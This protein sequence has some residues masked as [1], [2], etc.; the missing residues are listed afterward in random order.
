MPLSSRIDAEHRR[1]ASRLREGQR[2]R[3]AI[4]L[5]A[6][7]IHFRALG[8]DLRIV[9]IDDLAVAAWL[10]AETEGL[11]PLFDRRRPAEQ[12]RPGNALVNDDL[13]CA[14]HALVLAF[15]QKQR[16]VASL[17]HREHRL[18]CVSGLVDEP[19]ELLTIGLHIGD[20]TP[21]DAGVG[22]RLGYRRRDHFDETRSR[23]AWE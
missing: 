2:G 9:R 1:V 3:H 4:A 5:S 11:D 20:R 17:R 19:A 23:T 15:R 6:R 18:H 22:S 16:F 10:E 8:I 12:Q 13:R 21:G 7:M 14:Q